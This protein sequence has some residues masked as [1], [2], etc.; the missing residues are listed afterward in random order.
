MSGAPLI[1]DRKSTARPKSTVDEILGKPT[2]DEVLGK[3]TVDSILGPPSSPSIDAI[4]GPRAAKPWSNPHATIERAE[5]GPVQFTSD[6]RSP[7]HNRAVGGSPTSSHMTGQATD[8]RPRDGN[9]GAAMGKLEASGVPFDQLIAEGDHVHVGYGPKMRGQVT[10]MRG[11]KKPTT[12][13]ILG[14]PT[15]HDILGPPLP[16][17][18][19]KGDGSVLRQ[20]PKGLEAL[21]ENVFTDMERE[22]RSS[23]KALE[24]DLT[25]DK[26]N[27]D[28]PFTLAR[29]GKT[30]LDATETLFGGVS[31]IAQATV[32]SALYPT[33]GGVT[34]DSDKLRKTVG[35][36]L[37]MLTPI[38]GG[39]ELKAGKRAIEGGL[40]L[41]KGAMR[42]RGAKATFDDVLGPARPATGGR[43]MHADVEHDELVMPDRHGA[44]PVV[45]NEESHV[46]RVDNALYRLGNHHTASQIEAKQHL[47]ALPTEVKNPKVQEDLTH[48]LEE[49]LKNPDAPIPEH[50]QAAYDAVA[51]FAER[52][53]DAVN[54]LRERGDPEIEEYLADQGYV[55]RC[56][57][58]KSPGMD[59]RLPGD[60]ERAVLSGKSSLNTASKSLKS[61]SF[62]IVTDADGQEFFHEGK[63]N[64]TD[65][66]DRPYASVRQAT[67]KEIEANTDVRYHKNALVNTITR[68]LEDEKVVRNL[69]VLDELKAGLKEDGLAHQHEWHYP[70]DG[71]T[72]VRRANSARPQGF[73][74]LAHVPQLKGW[75][76][77]PRVAEA[78]KDYHPGEP[79]ALFEGIAKVNRALTASMFVSPIPHIA[80]VGTMAVIGRGLENTYAAVDPRFWKSAGRAVSEVWNMGSEYR[81]FLREGAGLRAADD[82]TRN[83]HEVMLKAA[84]HQTEGDPEAMRTIGDALKGTGVTAANAIKAY[85]GAVHKSLW[86][87]NDMILFQ[88]Q[89][90]L[91][92]RGMSAR[93]AIKE[94]EKWI[95]NYRVPPQVMGQRWVNQFFTSNVPV[96]FGRYRYGVYKSVA[97]M[98]RVALPKVPLAE[99][100]DIAG[101][102][103]MMGLVTFGVSKTMDK[104][105]QAATG[106]KN[107]R[108]HRGGET[109]MLDAGVQYAKG[110]KDWGATVASFLTPA[111]APQAFLEI[112]NNRKL[113]NGQRVIEPESSTAGKV[114]QGIGY[115]EQF[116][117]PA[118][119]IQKS[120]TT[121]GGLQALGSLAGVSLPTKDP[122]RGRAKGNA[123]DRRT[124]HRR[125]KKDPLTGALTRLGL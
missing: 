17:D 38:P 72:I 21:R 26:K 71:K 47:D 31:G 118:E 115:A 124:A 80:N 77:D 102:I 95:A 73:V 83:F 113:F 123:Y 121:G 39:A 61:R 58:G 114:A 1:T 13:D 69:E 74:E 23:R 51:P 125:D 112:A 34:G 66:R 40:D 30:A 44:G 52:Q 93:E 2:V 27:P 18:G 96:M 78:F 7:A 35:D 56:A 120:F 79:H 37:S 19:R 104:I 50:L 111:P 85:Y 48:A 29:A 87:A 67:V 119:D 68:A 107:A 5:G 109:G 49:R 54:R 84:G 97:N 59:L 16:A 90:E 106:N 15:V 45:G 32:G 41:A 86:M 62:H 92:A 63:V 75:S 43:T 57:K 117:T 70:E 91:E 110:E 101:K 82:A 9:L 10:A 105:A 108:V 24:Y 89:L 60:K 36:D 65:I 6:R 22:T 42:R 103:V 55:P 98:L 81:R 14:K 3:P 33:R 4:L 20:G 100:A 25:D 88:R 94:S 8:F 11:G 99:R 122:A 28:G 46:E 12:T 64:E 76:F 116:A 53:R